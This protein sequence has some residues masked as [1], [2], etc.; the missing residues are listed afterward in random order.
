MP[1]TIK[2]ISAMPLDI[3]TLHGPDILSIGETKTFNLSAF[4]E[5]VF[6]HSPL[7][8]VGV[9]DDPLDDLRKEAE[10]LGIE[11]DKRWGE[12][13]LRSEVDKALAK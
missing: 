12:K 4:D 5:E 2:N 8:I 9:E 7:V 11:V 1:T 10:D 6:R 13:R 3:P